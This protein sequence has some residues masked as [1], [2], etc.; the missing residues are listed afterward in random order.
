MEEGVSAEICQP[1]SQV[2]SILVPW[3]QLLDHII[4]PELSLDQCQVNMGYTHT[5]C[6]QNHLTQLEEL[7]YTD[8]QYTH[9][10]M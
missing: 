5:H 10:Q 8:V 7:R 4:K 9:V 1:S 3:Q 2:H 6:T